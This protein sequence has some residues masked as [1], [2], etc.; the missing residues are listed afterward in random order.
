[1]ESQQS[2]GL[3]RKVRAVLAMWRDRDS[4]TKHL[5]SIVNAIQQNLDAA[6]KRLDDYKLK[7]QVVQ[8][9]FDLMDARESKVLTELIEH[10]GLSV[11]AR[12]FMA[13]MGKT[14]YKGTVE[15]AWKDFVRRLS[16]TEGWEDS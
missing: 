14:Q 9:V 13:G 11:T 5:E 16:K 15:R 1:M 12:A 7:V 6:E 4:E 8:E 10:P 3:I 2:E